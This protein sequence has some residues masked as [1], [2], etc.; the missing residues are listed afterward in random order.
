MVG[1][2]CLILNISD[3]SSCRIGIIDQNVERK[4]CM[5]FNGCRYYPNN[6]RMND[7]QRRRV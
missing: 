6:T 1:G 7:L 2:M 4:M 3:Q 5:I